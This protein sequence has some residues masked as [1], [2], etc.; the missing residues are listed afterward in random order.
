MLRISFILAFWG[1]VIAF[2]I[3]SGLLSFCLR[4]LSRIFVSSRRR[5]IPTATRGGGLAGLPAGLAA[6]VRSQRAL[7]ATIADLRALGPAYHR[8]FEPGHGGIRDDRR[9]QATRRDFEDA[10]IHVTRALDDWCIRFNALDEPARARLEAAGTVPDVHALLREFRWLPRE[11]HQVGHLHFRN[12]EP[13]FEQRVF[14]LGEGL[15]GLDEALTH[16]RAQAYR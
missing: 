16:Q 2:A 14:E 12:D 1:L 9:R 10:V 15:H 5:P 13:A 11:V 3:S 6:L 4:M 7:E 8:S